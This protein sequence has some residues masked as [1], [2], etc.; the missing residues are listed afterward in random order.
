MLVPLCTSLCVCV[1]VFA[2]LP[3]PFVVDTY[4]VFNRHLIRVIEFTRSHAFCIA[5]KG[6]FACYSRTLTYSCVMNNLSLSLIHTYTHK[7][8]DDS[9]CCKKKQGR[10]TAAE[11]K[12]ASPRNHGHRLTSFCLA[13]IWEP[14]SDAHDFGGA[15]H[16]AT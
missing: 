14:V 1:C 11:H 10:G 9:V 4:L 12:P 8:W 13:L 3:V 6:Y 2:R 7:G 15:H 5:A 16:H